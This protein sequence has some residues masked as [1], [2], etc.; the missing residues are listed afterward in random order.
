MTITPPPPLAIDGVRFAYTANDVLHDV[1]FSV[2]PGEFVGVIGPNGA[3]KTTLLRLLTG[4]LHPAAGSVRAGATDVSRIAPLE[5]ARMMA[6]VPQNEAVVFA[7][8]V[9]AMVLLGRYPHAS[10]FGYEREDDYAA[11]REAMRLVGVEHLAARSMTELSGG[12]QH[13][14]FIARALAQQTPLLLLDE[15]NAH[16]DLRHQSLLFEL[17]SR[18]QRDHGRS[19]FIITHD[20]NLAGMYCDRILL[21]SDGRP[22]AWGTPAEVLREDIISEHFGVTVRIDGGDRPHVRLVRS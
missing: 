5:R 20:L 3:G 17:L 2:E 10:S 9:E 6:V 19:V 11:A 13:R 22:A 16:L 18:L 1:S 12:E 7:Y 14:V 8:T 15:P 21:L 4:Q